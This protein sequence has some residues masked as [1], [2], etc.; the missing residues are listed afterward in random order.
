M[1]SNHGLPMF[2]RGDTSVYVVATKCSTIIL[3]FQVLVFFTYNPVNCFDDPFM[4]QIYAKLT[5]LCTNN[6]CQCTEI[7]GYPCFHK[8]IPQ[9]TL[10]QL[11]AV[12]LAFQVLVSFT[13]NP[14][15]CFDDCFMYQN[16]LN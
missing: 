4:Y 1:Y 2:S 15:T 6:S 13:Y 8:G 5:H 11:S 10:W 12:I 3:A 14:V 7:T 16:M 9:F